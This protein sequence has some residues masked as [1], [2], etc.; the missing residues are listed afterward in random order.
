MTIEATAT[1]GRRSEKSTISYGMT[2]VN[3]SRMLSREFPEVERWM[4]WNMHTDPAER[5][6][7][8]FPG[9]GNTS[10]GKMGSWTWERVPCEY[11]NTG[12]WTGS[13]KRLKYGKCWV[14]MIRVTNR[15][16]ES[17]LIF[18]YLRFDMSIGK[19]YIV[20]TGDFKLLRRF[21]G[22]V[23]RHMR[24]GGKRDIIHV[25]VVNQAKDFQLK[26]SEIEPVYLPEGLHRDIYAQV[27]GFF[28]GHTKYKRLGIPFKR[29]FLFTGQPGTGKTMLIRNLIRHVHSKH[30]I[31]SCYL[32]IHRRVDADDL[33]LLFN[34]AS[35]KRPA[36]VILEDVESL[37][38]ETIITRAELLAALDGIGQHTGMLLI[39]TA[40]DP[41]RIDPALVHRPS[42]FDRVWTFPL[43]DYALRVRYIREQFGG[44]DAAL[45][46]QVAY[47]TDDWTFAYI[48]ELR[49]TAG[50]LSINAGAEAIQGDHVKEALG[51]L[52]DQ[53]KSGKTGHAEANRKPNN[54]VGFQFDHGRRDRND[55]LEEVA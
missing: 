48:K 24:P 40:N 41:S 22:A 20:S 43:P 19:E 39:A 32:H 21:A 33:Q 18:S 16:G 53:F 47:E 49:N 46:E 11:G 42:R 12:F 8:S 6:I 28:C 44:I 29:G 23:M 38:H 50:I 17:F 45:A 52:R 10:S 14:G 2:P 25:N 15:T 3:A 4:L 34:C 26:A 54:P 1:F 35:E 37:C 31:P 9:Q 36:L 30:K 5:A 51:L 27:D 55:E 7:S 13:T